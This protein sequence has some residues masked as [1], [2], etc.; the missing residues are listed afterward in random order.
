MEAEQFATLDDTILYIWKNAKNLSLNDIKR[1]IQEFNIVLE[2]DENKGL[3]IKI[4]E[5]KIIPNQKIIQITEKN[6]L[7]ATIIP[8]IT[9]I[10]IVSKYIKNVIPDM[11][12]PP[13]ININL[14]ER[15]KI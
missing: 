11:R 4:K 5:H 6:Q 14:I 9:M 7:I 8:R 12:F 3:E 13:K 10:S 2:E 15:D 1:I